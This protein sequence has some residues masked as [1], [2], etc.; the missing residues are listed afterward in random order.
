MINLKLF[1][2]RFISAQLVTPLIFLLACTLVQAAEPVKIGVQAVRS[3]EQT[4]TQWRP[5]ATALKQ[6]IPEYDFIIEPLVHGEMERAVASRQLDFV[7]TNPAHYVLMANRTGLSS[8]LATLADS[9]DG[10]AVSVFGG[11]IFTRADQTNINHLSDIKGKTIATPTIESLGAYQMQAYEL[12]RAGVSLPQDARVLS[13]GM[14]QDNVVEAVLAGRAEVGFV[15]TGL[16]KSMAREGRLNMA[17]IK[18]INQQKFSGY[19]AFA[20]THLYPNWAFAAL[21][22]IDENLARR[23]T[24][25]LLRIEENTA[26]THAMGIHGFVIPADYTPVENML[27]ELRTP[28]FENAPD[29]TLQDIWSQYRWPIMTMLATFGLALLMGV[30]LFRS[31]H[32]LRDEQRKG[33]LQQQALQESEQRYRFLFDNNPMP[34]WVFAE[35]TLKFL[36]VNQRAVE[37][38]GFS[39]NEFSRMTLGDIRPAED[40]QSL[41]AILA[42]SP[43]GIRV[44]EVRHKKKDG[45]LIN[46]IVSTM[47][48]MFDNAKARIV[49]VQDITDRKRAE[50]ELRMY[51]EHLEDQIHERTAD[52]VLALHAAESANKAKSVFLSNMSHE[53][54]TPLNAILGFSSL[55]RKDSSL[56]QEQC[57]DLDIINRSGEHLLTLINDVL[58]MAK[59]E[60][61]R[62][63]LENAPLDLGTLVRDV[64]DMMHMRAH[65]KGL[66]LLLDQTSEFPRYIKGDEARLRQILI[67]LVSNAVKFTQQGGVTLRLGTRENAISHLVIEVE[68]S[69]PGIIPE[70]QLRIFQPFVQLGVQAEN[71]GTGLGLTITRQFVQLMGGSIVLESTP[72]KGSL[73]R[74]DLP[75]TAIS[76]SDIVKPAEVKQG[77]VLGLVPG[78]PE[79][80]ILIVEDQLENQLLLTELMKRLGVSVRLAENGEQGVSMFTSWHPHL[81]WMDWRM[82]VM[83]G[84][85][86]TRRIRELPGGRAVKIV[87]VTASAFIEQRKE[88]FTAGMDDFVRKPYRANE[89][90]ECMF[91]QLG[92]KYVY[93]NNQV[94]E[95]ATFE[96]V[97]TDKMLAVLPTDLRSELGKAL[98]SLED[99]RINDAI[100]QVAAY[101]KELHKVLTH[102]AQNF[103]YPAI[104]KALQTN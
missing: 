97:L 44:S 55:L 27:R 50:Q 70:D 17:Q 4:L 46:V 19:S 48:M 82:P 78:Q 10:Q 85:A 90:Y 64:T 67:N 31:N 98:D 3:K 45:A 92:V 104:L 47:P 39:R 87:A 51:K 69:G 6:I 58:E 56:R 53:L 8:P 83:D 54:R 35:D 103:D 15:R 33:L 100:G 52:L 96:T 94:E 77:D 75:L 102:L 14:P 9:E 79:C 86:A 68:D 95:D 23:V 63:Q 37:H 71:K 7:L 20:S 2:R 25:A 73:F 99:K 57:E 12:L 26:S 91:R 60:A 1:G 32:R 34:M 88:I 81:I 16:L 84:L 59:I 74:V 21:P 41:L 93:A 36:E 65:E 28:P 11:V 22:N 80:R 42:S 49:L 5:L 13:T 38:Y 62:V 76:E 66:Q 101:D 18:I 40:M 43:D 61:G 30:G 29:V 89:I 72:G 24:A